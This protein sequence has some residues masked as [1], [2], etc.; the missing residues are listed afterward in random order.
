VKSNYKLPV[1]ALVGLLVGASGDSAIHG[2]Q[3]KSSPVYLVSE[4]DAITDS[5]AIKSYGAQVHQTLTPFNGHYHFVVAGGKTE[6]L[7]GVPPPVGMVVIA[8][9]SSEQAHA[10]Y[11]SPTYKAIRQIRQAAV[12]GRMFIVEGVSQ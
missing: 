4:A 10:W 3:A 8:F 5:T 1:A 2:Q 7:D 11:D 9:D 12:K 6:S